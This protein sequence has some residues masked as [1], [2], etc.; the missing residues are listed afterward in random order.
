MTAVAVLAMGL[1]QPA[2]GALTDNLLAN[3]SFDEGS[4]TT[5]SDTSGSTNTHDGTLVNSPVWT[6][7]G[8]LN[9][10]LD[11]GSGGSAY[12]EVPDHTELQ[13]STSFTISAWFYMPSGGLSDLAGIVVKDDGT[14]N[15]WVALWSDEDV[16]FRT[17]SGGT[18]ISVNTTAG[19]D[20]DAWHHVVAAYDSSA[21]TGK[22]FVDGVLIETQS[23]VGTPDTSTAKLT[24]GAQDTNGFR[25]F[26]DRI[27]EVAIWSRALSD[28]GVSDGQTAGGEVAELWNSGDGV[29]IPEPATMTLLGLG[30]LALLIRRRRR[31]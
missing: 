1:A 29:Q 22:L 3:W 13:L 18:D 25:S 11:F 15:Y 4:G 28:G 27:D 21:N 19:V 26:T 6:T 30:G 9:G 5:A 20:E 7:S 16:F 2:A 12:V 23:N 8:K 14:R 10:A 17:A 24:I 31:A